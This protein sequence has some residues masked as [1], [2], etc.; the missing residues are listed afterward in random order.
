MPIKA[1]P[2]PESLAAVKASVLAMKV[3]DK[4]LRKVINDQTRLEGNELWRGLLAM[5][6]TTTMDMRM[7]V[8][9]A[10]VAAGNPPRLIA[11]ASKRK[12]LSGG[13]TPDRYG[14][15]AE[16]GVKDREATSTYERKSRSGGTHQVTRRTRRGLPAY[17]PAGRVVWP[18]VADAMPRMIS[19]WTQTIIRT[20]YE[21]FEGK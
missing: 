17:E 15:T 5:N 6:A 7:L 16:F 21:K 11:A 12:A 8:K 14:K 18:A 9:G 3:M 13:M 10:R 1:G 19:L 4:D 2:T 20:V